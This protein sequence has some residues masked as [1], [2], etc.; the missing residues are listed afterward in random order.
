MHLTLLLYP[1]EHRFSAFGTGRSTGDGRLSLPC[2]QPFCCHVLSEAA[3]LPEVLKLAL[4][5]SLKHLVL[6]ETKY[7]QRICGYF[8]IAVFQS[9]VK[10]AF[11]R[12]DVSGG[13][14]QITVGILRSV[15]PQLP[16]CLAIRIAYGPD[17]SPSAQKEIEY[18][19]L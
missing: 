8:G 11:L 14:M 15:K 10:L 9:W 4:D 3:G 17:I 18:V 19:P 5:L 13:I 16:D 1:S 6:S 2:L 12:Q 7:Q